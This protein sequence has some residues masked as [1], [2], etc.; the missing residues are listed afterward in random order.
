MDEL[1]Q[2]AKQREPAALRELVDAHYDDVY[3]FCARQVGQ[4]SASDIAQETF[5]TMQKNIAK[6]EGRST[7]R[8]WL[9]GIALN[10]SRGMQRT[11]GRETASLDDW[12]PASGP[13]PEETV[14]TR[15]VLR[16][17]LS[18]LT[19]EH[20]EVVLL[21]EVEGLKY[22]EIADLLSI[23]EGTVKSRLHHA[24]LQLRE[25]IGGVQ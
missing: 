10:H 15:E 22:R 16:T 3:R 19:D 1:I 20:R 2:R 8:T 18:N 25:S 17:A 12:I 23:P 6:F 11:K 5:L 13:S 21:H 7:F 24:F 14:T 9:F 4:D